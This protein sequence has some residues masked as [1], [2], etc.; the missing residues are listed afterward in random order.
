MAR[1]PE[2][3][4]H[5]R[6]GSRLTPMLLHIIVGLENANFSFEAY[7]RSKY[8][9]GCANES[10]YITIPVQYLMLKLINFKWQTS[11]LKMEFL[12]LISI[13]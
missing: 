10:W 7:F 3:Q 9:P 1:N 8:K 11:K 5:S 12:F 13:L 2:E 4:I 6:L